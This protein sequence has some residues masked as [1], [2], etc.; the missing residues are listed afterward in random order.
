MIAHAQLHNRN[1]VLGRAVAIYARLL[2]DLFSKLRPRWA[3]GALVAAGHTFSAAPGYRPTRVEQ[4]W[5]RWALCQLM[6]PTWR[7]RLAL[8]LD[9][10]RLE[11]FRLGKNK[12]IWS[13]G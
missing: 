8:P 7:E 4:A 10:A 5:A 9:R 13:G 11:V 3:V 1:A 2:D 12:A 6:R